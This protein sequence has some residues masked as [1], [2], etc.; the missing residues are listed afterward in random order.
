VSFPS[1]S[2]AGLS[3][4]NDGEMEVDNGE[5]AEEKARSKVIVERDLTERE[6]R[7][8]RKRK[9]R[10]RIGRMM[11]I[12]RKMEMRKMRSKTRV[13]PEFHTLRSP[14]LKN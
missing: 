7:L 6:L 3:W 10:V 1:P 5:V 11:E 2:K 4:I 13:A 9:M 12:R 14:R 8:A